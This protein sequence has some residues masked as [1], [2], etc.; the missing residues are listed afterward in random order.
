MAVYTPPETYSLLKYGYRVD[1]A[2]A[3][4]PA[5]TQAALFTISG[6]LVAITKIIGEVTT[7]IQTQANN[8]KLV[9]NPTVGTDVDLCAVLNITADE[10][11]TLYSISGTLATALIGVNAGA[12][13]T[14]TNEIVV[15][16]G[17][18]DL[19][20]AAT[21]TGEIKWSLWYIPLDQGARVVAA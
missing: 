9:S 20:C 18:I 17:T 15:P 19:D 6:G 2:T 5:S 16:E 11:G 3:T 7:V 8:T 13:P 4:L 21:N 12:V 10:V 14:Q 1:R